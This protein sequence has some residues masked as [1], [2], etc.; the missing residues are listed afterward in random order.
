[1]RLISAEILA[2]VMTALVTKG[3][4]MAET[5]NNVS[6]LLSKVA[7]FDCNTV[8]SAIAKLIERA[9]SNRQVDRMKALISAEKAMSRAA[10][11]ED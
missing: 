9:G 8:K 11:I 4:E 3:N 2:V 6:P 7:A 10:E 5:A 1:M